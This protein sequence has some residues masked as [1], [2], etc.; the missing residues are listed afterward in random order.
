MILMHGRCGRM[1]SEAPVCLVVMLT[2]LAVSPIHA[3][4]PHHVFHRLVQDFEAR[5]PFLPEQQ[6][7]WQRTVA[8]LRPRAAHARSAEELWGVMTELL[9]PLN[10]PHVRLE[11]PQLGVFSI[12]TQ[13]GAAALPQ[14]LRASGDIGDA[15]SHG[16]RPDGVLYLRIHHFRGTVAR[17]HWL[18]E[19]D[20]LLRRHADAP[21]VLID[22]RDNPGGNHRVAR[23][24]AEAFAH[25]RRHY[26][27]IRERGGGWFSRSETKWFLQPRKVF[28]RDRPVSVLTN[29]NTASAAEVFVLAMRTLPNV[30]HTGERTAGASGDTDTRALPNGW[31]YTL[32]TNLFLDRHGKPYAIRGIAPGG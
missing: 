4:E 27:S 5:Y 15:I 22:V 12:G 20:Q 24:I 23:H 30:T 19:L 3:A 17:A 26:L 6:P 8:A 28:P 11:A 1:L 7:I 14:D 16:L 29:R 2:A 18:G 13:P 25:Q 21:G 9:R 10:D 31:R 32:P